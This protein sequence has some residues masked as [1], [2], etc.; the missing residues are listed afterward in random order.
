LTFAK[1]FL[2]N[3]FFWIFGF[4]DFLQISKLFKIFG[5]SFLFLFFWKFSNGLQIYKNNSFS[6]I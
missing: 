5:F 4:L 6:S 3:W 2:K 1:T